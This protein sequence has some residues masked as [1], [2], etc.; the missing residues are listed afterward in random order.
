MNLVGNATYYCFDG[1]AKIVDDHDALN[2]TVRLF[3]AVI[4]IVNK[5]CA[6]PVLATLQHTFRIVTEFNAAR[7]LAPKVNGMVSG[8]V[9][10]FFKVTSQLMLIVADFRGLLGW[11]EKMGMATVAEISMQMGRIPVLGK[12]TTVLFLPGAQS[13]F[14]VMGFILSFTDGAV[15]AI[16]RGLSWKLVLKQIGNLSKITGVL[17]I[18]YTS[19]GCFMLGAVANSIGSLSYLG[20]FLMTAYGL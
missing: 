20:G 4:D 8:E 5:N 2:Q 7:S 6:Q 9:S 11:L 3:H 14:S 18:G 17:L 15:E 12:L 16:D 1:A 13:T 19:Y 10:G